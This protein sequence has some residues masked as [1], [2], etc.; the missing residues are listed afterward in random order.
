MNYTI[1][2]KILTKY[3]PCQISNILLR[4]NKS[5]R[6]SR[7]I[8]PNIQPFGGLQQ[9]FILKFKKKRHPIV[10]FQI[11]ALFINYTNS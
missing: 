1:I 10:I 7:K 5:L 9:M 6:V 3:F 11:I 8:Y 2:N 4:N